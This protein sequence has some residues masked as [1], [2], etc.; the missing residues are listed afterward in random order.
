MVDRACV[1][2]GGT[3]GLNPDSRDVRDQVSL[4]RMQGDRASAR[5]R[6]AVCGVTQSLGSGWKELPRP[7]GGA[8]YRQPGL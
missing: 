6:Q 2:R 4:I 5:L 3:C 7:E 8:Q 1:C